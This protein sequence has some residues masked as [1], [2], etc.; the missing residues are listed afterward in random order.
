MQ[1]RGINTWTVYG[2]SVLA[3]TTFRWRGACF[4]LQLKCTVSTRNRAQGEPIRG[5]DDLSNSL[6]TDSWSLPASVAN[7]VPLSTGQACR[8][9]P[10]QWFPFGCTAADKTGSWARL[11][12]RWQAGSNGQDQQDEITSPNISIVATPVNTHSADFG[13]LGP[14]C[15]QTNKCACAPSS[16]ETT[17]QPAHVTRV[18]TPLRANPPSLHG[19]SALWA[20]FTVT[21]A[22]RTTLCPLP[23]KYH[24]L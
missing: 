15:L 17:T 19:T 18:G 16:L 12:A 22:I 20:E 10:V 1:I 5:T 11:L 24:Y 13:S 23:T 6:K 8:P 2:L 9:S 4:V 3:L 14:Y 21:K 7:H